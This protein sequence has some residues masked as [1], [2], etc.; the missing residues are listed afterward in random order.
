MRIPNIRFLGTG[1]PRA[2]FDIHRPEGGTSVIEVSGLVGRALAQYFRQHPAEL[3]YIDRRKFEELVAEIWFGFGYEVE[4]TKQTRDGGKDIIAVGGR[5]TS[6]RYLI[7]CKRPDPPTKI[8]VRPVRELLGVKQDDPA[9]KAI[10][11]TTSWFTEDARQIEERN[12][13]S[14]ELRDYDG[15]MVWLKTYGLL[16]RD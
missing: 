15:L 3:V 2:E 10:L 5:E 7:E 13:W 1:G 8:D 12:R 14:L 6:N 4:L 16:A 11:V 9:T